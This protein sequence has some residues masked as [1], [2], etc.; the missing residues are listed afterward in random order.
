VKSSFAGITGKMLENSPD[1][2][3]IRNRKME[4]NKRQKV[5]VR[6]LES[7]MEDLEEEE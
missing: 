5:S 7:L 4:P 3:L 6:D 1:Q 2:S